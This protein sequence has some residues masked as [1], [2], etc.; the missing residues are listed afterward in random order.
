[1]ATIF[2]KSEITQYGQSSLLSYWI[3]FSHGNNGLIKKWP[4]IFSKCH[5]KL[6]EQEL[7]CPFCSPQYIDELRLKKHL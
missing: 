7:K 2:Y 3:E 4:C 6:L 1:M 5:F